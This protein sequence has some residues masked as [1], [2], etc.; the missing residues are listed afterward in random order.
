MPFLSIII[1]AHNSGSTLRATLSS[2][3]LALDQTEDAEVVILND[4]STDATQNIIDEWRL[5][6]PNVRTEQVSYRNVGKVRQHAISLSSGDYITML[7]SDDLLKPKSLQDAINFLRVNKP[8][9]LISRLLEV[10]D[11]NEAMAEWRGFSPEILTK[12]EAI[13]RFLIHRDFQA[14]LAGKFIR[15]EL[16]LQSP[17]PHISCYEDFAVFPAMMMNSNNIFYQHDGYYC[18]VKTPN[19]L[20]SAL[21]AD[22]IN[23]LYDCT[24]SMEQTLPSEYQQLMNCHWFNMY[25]NHGK[26]L[27]KTQLNTVKDRVGRIYSLSFFLSKDIRFS[28]KKR[29]IKALWK[30]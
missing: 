30:K 16:Y 15:R 10:N 20:S 7:D 25:V 11:P 8:D 5:Q 19:S 22:K 23:H 13:R 3:L 21:N 29:A 28:F 9:M 6:L 12:Q 2:L 18:Y 26:H 4:S 24:L 14:H 17:I 27:T 1:A